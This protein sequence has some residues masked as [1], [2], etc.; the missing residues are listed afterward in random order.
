MRLERAPARAGRAISLTPLIDVVFILLLFFL[1]ASHFD[2][3]GALQLDTSASLATRP[4]A[5]DAQTL[6][7][8]LHADGALELNGEALDEA[9]LG[10]RLESLLAER[11]GLALVV[12]ADAEVPLQDLVSLIDHIVALGVQ[13][14][15]L[16]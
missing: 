15:S 3:W 6:L 7:L 9:Y 16:R 11:P 13:E 2:Q 5:A 14:V 1:L 8:R 4:S 10:A 12:Q